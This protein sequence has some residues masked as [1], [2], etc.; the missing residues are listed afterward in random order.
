MMKFRSLKAVSSMG[1][2][3]TGLFSGCAQ[4]VSKTGY[5]S[6]ELGQ[7]NTVVCDPFG[8]NPGPSSNNGL[9]ALLTFIPATSSIVSN[10]PAM[11]T[12]TFAPGQ[13]DVQVAPTRIV[14]NKIAVSTRDF[15][16]GF[17]DSNGSKLK[18]LAGEDLI[19]WFSLRV[20][21]RVMANTDAEA[22]LYQFAIM[23]DDGS[24][25]EI[26]PTG[27]GN[28]FQSLISNDHQRNNTL[29]C[30]STAIPLV[31][32]QGLPIKINY[33]QGPRVRISF[34]LLWRKVPNNNPSSLAE[35]EC[36]VNRADTYYFTPSV[37]GP[38]PT[39]KYNQLISRGWKIIP[40]ANLYFSDGS[41]TN[42]CAI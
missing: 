39:T 11:T 40:E 31:R 30:S 20:R 9:D 25:M 5:I 32:N 2:L 36:G 6:S 18:N 37:S 8:G 42:P 12:E 7:S 16:D 4:D 28:S 29:G 26:D 23:S 22:G 41:Q 13:T 21:G 24:V 27:S 19:E 17:S 3:M 10:L 33:F 38:V 34:S 35:V 15:V 1:L 14:L